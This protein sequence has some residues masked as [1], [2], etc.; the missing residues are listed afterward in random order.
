MTP[1]K[2]TP[3]TDRKAHVTGRTSD[4]REIDGAVSPERDVDLSLPPSEYEEDIVINGVSTNE[5]ARRG[6]APPE[7]TAPESAPEGAP[8]A[9][10]KP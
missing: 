1:P 5:L 9:V 4:D 6:A 7:K 3:E 2:S 8:K 10:A